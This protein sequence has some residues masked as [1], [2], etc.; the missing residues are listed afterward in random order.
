MVDKEC[1]WAI[2]DT[3][4]KLEKTKKFLKGNADPD[5]LSLH[6]SMLRDIESQRKI[7]VTS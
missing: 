3:M 5:R 6:V 1:V 7:P 4:A 2:T